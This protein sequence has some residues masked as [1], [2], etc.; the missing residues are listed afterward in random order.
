[1]TLDSEAW[2]PPR[3]LEFIAMTT[4]RTSPR[5]NSYFLVERDTLRVRL[6]PMLTRE[7]ARQVKRSYSDNDMLQIAKA[8]F[9]EFVR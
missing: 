3:P 9:C 8:T 2:N 4:Q 5:I 6:G 7:E 1:M